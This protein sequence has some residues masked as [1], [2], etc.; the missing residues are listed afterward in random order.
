MSCDGLSYKTVRELGFK[1]H[2][3]YCSSPGRQG[4]K[5]NLVAMRIMVISYEDSQRTGCADFSIFCQSYLFVPNVTLNLMLFREVFPS[6]VIQLQQYVP[7]QVY[8]FKYEYLY[9]KFFL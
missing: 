4:E 1:L 6:A 2:Y 5:K 9:S 7:L 3:G 8:F